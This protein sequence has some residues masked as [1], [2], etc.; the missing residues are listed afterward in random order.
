MTLSF[1]RKSAVAAVAAVL[2]SSGSISSGEEL[3]GMWV[4]A[5]GAGFLDQSQVTKLVQDARDHNFNALFVHM[6]RRGDAFYFPQPPNQDPRTT[7]IAS[8]YDA[9]AEIIAQAHSGS[10][11]LEVHCWVVSNLI[12]SNET[13]APSQPGHVYNQHPE[14]LMKNSVGDTFIGEGY[15]LDPGHPDA[16]QWNYN[17]AVDI[18]SNYAIDGFHWDYIRYPQQD[19]G[20]N[21]TAV[22][23]YNAEFGLTG[24]PSPSDPQFSDWRRRQMSDFLRWANGNLL[25]IRPNL[26]I[27]TA[28]F[29][30]RTDA[31]S[32]RFQ[33]WAAWNEDGIIDLCIPMNYTSTNSTF[34]SRVD[35][36]Y[37]HQGVRVAYIGQGAYLNSK[38][39][40]VTQLNYVRNK[41]MWGT[42]LYSYRTPNSGTVDQAGT[43]AYIR[44]NYQPTW[45][46]TPALP[47]KANPET[48]IVKGTITD[49]VTG[50]VIYNATVSIDAG[51]GFSQR[52]CVRGS[53]GFFDA[54]DGTWTVTA[55]AAGYGEA[56]AS[57]TVIPG[58]VVTVNLQLPEGDSGPVEDIIID[59]PGAA[60]AGSWSTGTSSADK[61]GADYRFKGQ[62]DGSS[63]LQYTPEIMTAG[64]YHVYEWHPQGSNRTLGAPHVISHSSGS[65]TVLV[66]QQVN[67]GQWNYLG[68]YPFAVGSAGHVRIT[69]G[70]ADGGQVVLAD[71]VSFVYAGENAPS[72]VR[73]VHVEDIVMSWVSGPGKRVYSRATVEIRDSD[74]LVVEGA[75]VTGD[76][77]GAISETGASAVTGTDGKAAITS[78]ASI[79]TGT[80]T[81]TVTDVSGE[82]LE[83]DAAA[84]VVSSASATR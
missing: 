52:S 56:S 12:W 38:E 65:E 35:D 26:V 63:Y 80:V 14:Y 21:D 3:R 54:D 47:W 77:S 13:T 40:T 18:V 74:G 7:A 42:L 48:G 29:A 27:S 23:R 16:M 50:E 17:M 37:N 61:Y 72:P 11:R 69:D 82:G 78:E 46:E 2:L 30:S 25:E 22:A 60:V 20:Y 15:Y 59:N 5:W 36:A 10:P 67:G 79:R 68:T 32:Y 75:T 33:D 51:L 64:D 76:F 9:L 44:D 34:N 4:D 28:V 49:A 24:Q 41:P 53:Y 45:V 73:M 70:F 58:Q 83:Y 81:F 62:G 19:S 55:T 6:R 66:N 1:L 71:A 43:F 31:Y 57:V 84:N 39:N 8:D